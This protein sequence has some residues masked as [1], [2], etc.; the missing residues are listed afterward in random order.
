MPESHA[1]D[2]HADAASFADDVLILLGVIFIAVI[3]VAGYACVYGNWERG[4]DF[5][6]IFLP[7]T[8][9]LLGA[10]FAA[11]FRS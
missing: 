7:V 1:P 11:S 9:M 2:V 5:I 4:E 10:A 3:A 8:C 6:L